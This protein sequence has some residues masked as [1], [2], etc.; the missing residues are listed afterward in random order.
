MDN[1]YKII[2]DSTLGSLR[3]SDD[4]ICTIARI[5]AMEVSG[6]HDVAFPQNTVRGFLNRSAIVNPI[7][8]DVEENDVSIEISIIVEVGSTIPELAAA[9]QE[10]IKSAVET[11]AGLNVTRVDVRVAGI[12][13]EKAKPEET[14]AAD[15]EA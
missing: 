8:V 15:D 12:A 4:V 5:A 2:D 7:K 9:V 10:N 6:V 13:E 14:A 11:S 1:E 3:I